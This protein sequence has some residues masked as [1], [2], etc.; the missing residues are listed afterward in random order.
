M[1]LYL[2]CRYPCSRF[3]SLVLAIME[4]FARLSVHGPAAAAT[5]AASSLRNHTST[6]APRPIQHAEKAEA[7]HQGLIKVLSQ[8]SLASEA[9]MSTSGTG[10]V[11]MKYGVGGQV[12]SPSSSTLGTGLGIND[13]TMTRNSQL[14]IGSIATARNG[15][16]STR[17]GM[18]QVAGRHSCRCSCSVSRFFLTLL[19]IAHPYSPLNN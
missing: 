15:A 12:R 16:S 8:A 3:Q 19:W 9:S 1:L 7:S 14:Y 18:C 17:R 2:R 11:Y 5:A 6:S 10:V 13:G 4:L